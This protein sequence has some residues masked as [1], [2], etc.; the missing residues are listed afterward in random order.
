MTPRQE[1]P[2]SERTRIRESTKVFPIF[3]AA[4]LVE[5]EQLVPFTVV[6]M[7][8]GFLIVQI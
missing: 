2:T 6:F 8:A 1:F 7:F 5:L 3:S 4:A